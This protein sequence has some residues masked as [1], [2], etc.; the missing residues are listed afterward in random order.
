MNPHN[1]FTIPRGVQDTLFGYSTEEGMTKV[2]N[3]L[4]ICE[5]SLPIDGPYACKFVAELGFD[6]LQINIGDYERGFSMSRKVVQEAY[7]EM[8][9]ASGIE[10]P[11]L[12]ARVTDYYTLFPS[13]DRGE[14]EIVR[15]G[16]GKAIESCV[17]MKIPM[18]LIPNFEKSAR[19]GPRPRLPA[20]LHPLIGRRRRN[21][22]PPPPCGWERRRPFCT[23]SGC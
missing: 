3:K 9:E 16:I 17:S 1:T 22:V 20:R 19:T 23:L 13:K 10:F 2:T 15:S 18:L 11:S 14:S 12:V 8:G 5:W 21:A 6:G 7:M 4:G